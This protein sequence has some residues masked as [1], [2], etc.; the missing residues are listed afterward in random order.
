LNDLVGTPTEVVICPYS[1]E[2]IVIGGMDKGI[3]RNDVAKFI[4]IS[5]NVTDDESGEDFCTEP[6][7]HSLN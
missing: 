3:T 7:T 6:V 4:D 1:L 5:F 2:I